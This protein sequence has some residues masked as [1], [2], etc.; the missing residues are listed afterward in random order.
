MILNKFFFKLYKKLRD[1]YYKNILH[2]KRLFIINNKE[3][4]SAFN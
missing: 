1:I 2:K 4:L 3:S